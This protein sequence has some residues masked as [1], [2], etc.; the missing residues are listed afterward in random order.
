MF[1]C[2]LTGVFV[3]STKGLAA[4]EITAIDFN[5][6]LI[7]KVIPD[8]KV[9]NFDNQLI[10][11]INADS[12]IVGFKGELLG[13]II[14][15]G[16]AIG[17]D[18]KFL[19]KVSND[20]TVRLASGKII[21]KVLPNGLVVDE[22][23]DVIGAV[24]FPGLI[25]SNY[26]ET[27]GRLTGDGS[28]T[29][30]QGQ[31]IGFVSS[32]GY[33]YRQVG[34]EYVLDGKLISSKMVISDQGK[35]IGSLAPG[36]DVTDFEANI[37]GRIRANGYVYDAN[38][39]V[40]GRVV[41][42]GF[43]VGNDGKYLGFI[44]YNGEVILN[45]KVVGRLLA[46]DDIVNVEGSV[47]GKRI[48]FSATFSNEKG[49]YIGRLI[50]NGEIVKAKEVVGKLGVG[51][52]V[53]NEERI[54][55]HEVKTGPVFDYKGS[56]IGHALRN[57]AVISVL[58]TPLG[59]MKADMAYDKSGRF[60]GKISQTKL[61]MGLDN[62]IQGLT[63]IDMTIGREEEKKSVSPFGY[64]F[65][66]EGVLEGFAVKPAPI[67]NLY[68]IKAADLSLNGQIENQGNA[69][70]GKITTSGIHIDE[71]NR[72]LGAFINPKLVVDKAEES[73]YLSASNLVYNLKQ[74][75]VG[76]ITP[77]NNI[78][79]ASAEGSTNLMPKIGQAYPHS[80]VLNV[81]GNLVGYGSGERVKNSADSN[82]G[83]LI[84]RGIA[85]DNKGAFLGELASYETVVDNA[86]AFIGIVTPRGEV[87][88]YRDTYIGRPLLNGEVIS[89]SG[90]VLGHVVKALP[91]IGNAGNVLG[92]T[93]VD[94]KVI[95]Y[96]NDNLGCVDVYGRLMNVDGSIV[97]RT[98]INAPAIDFEGVIIGQ[99]NITG[100][101]ISDESKTLGYMQVDESVNSG[102]G[103][104][105]GTLFKYKYAFDN[106][107]KFIGIVN[108]EARVIGFD[109]KEIGYVD[110]YG[111]V[112]S[113]REKIG[114]ALYDLY[115]HG[116]ED[117][118]QGYIAADGNVLAFSGANIGKLDK[119][120]V[121]DKSGKVIARGSRDYNIR[122]DKYYVLGYLNFN[123]DVIANSGELAGKIE[124]KEGNIYNAEEQ[125]IAKAYPLQYYNN[126]AT[127][128]PVYGENGEII[129]YA[130]DDGS[131]VDEDGKLIALLNDDGF[132]ISANGDIIGGTGTDWFTKSTQRKVKKY[133]VPE[134]GVSGEMTEQ[135]RKSMSI[136]L[137]TDGEYLGRIG[138][139]GQVTDDSGKVLGRK[140][141]DGLIIDD[142][143]NLIGLEETAQPDTNGIFIPT[144]TF[145]QGS[146][147]GVGAGAGGNLGP[148]GGYGP[149][150][151]YDPQRSAALNEA[152]NQRRQNISVGKISTSVKTSN[153]DGMQKN[154]DEQGIQKAISS[155]RVDLSEMILSDKP[156]PAVIARSIDSNNPTPVTAY[157]ERNVYSEV[158]RNI[159]IPAGSR[160]MGTLG[161]LTATTE[162]TSQSAKVSIT[163]E[164]LIRPD[165]SIFVF[166]GLTGDAQGRGGAL[167]YLDQQLFKKYTLPVMTTMLSSGLTYMM[168]TDDSGSN[169]ESSRQQAANDA[170]QNFENSMNSIFQ[171]ILQDKTNI[172]PL[173][174]VPAGTRIIIYP[175]VDLWLRTP[176]RDE[177]EANAQLNK[178]DVLIDDQQKVRE[179]REVELRKKIN[180]SGN[181][182]GGGADSS[183]VV[184]APDQDGVS[185]ATGDALLISDRKIV[186]DRKKM[187]ASKKA[188][189]QN[190]SVGTPPPPPPS[191]ASSASSSSKE[192]TTTTTNSI[193][194]LF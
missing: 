117:S 2:V 14:P 91:V 166:Q 180:P 126:V 190:T 149:G 176:E 160:V 52:A 98:V 133:D 179:S 165:G 171:Q 78:I 187:D 156:I 58:G 168:A 167:G 116:E 70:T 48:D 69:Y 130:K 47:V 158:G 103:I 125:Y 61:V 112:N 3:L 68:G 22:I 24:L 140:M 41:S 151:R 191:S 183:S 161:G 120:F 178:K 96:N 26:G 177:L 85:I 6:D 54:L 114:Y 128:K 188:A 192:T 36:G 10:G 29:N 135:A 53:F 88:N 19:G 194:Q 90:A 86:C 101:V 31:K 147:Y 64:V 159:I 50:P 169:V 146:A 25:Y 72:V 185:E 105:L 136:A 92:I 35:F 94:G 148:G 8:G 153:F 139:D 80:I 62:T 89:D 113:G 152:Q 12:L 162:D 182:G 172:R 119:G 79:E 141:P 74:K 122:N 123:G 42:T 77:N 150:E 9:V 163:W 60:I 44:T 173:T 100:A 11:N 56:L 144:G 16:I 20:G 102:T 121:L 95:N 32:D 118:L 65:S 164:R 106:G 174:Y 132:A 51:N 40:I 43:A 83:K 15:Q 73:L 137:T 5:G 57:S 81:T 59:N 55:G 107:N 138:D 99:T 87:K 145:G 37:I 127:A 193:P 124:L 143:G 67:Y 142:G 45:E 7:G 134:V 4:Q 39:R 71:R 175:N 110:F 109:K 115:V 76:K 184:Y 181:T 34:N 17:N 75:I 155:W 93:S 1:L 84:E 111:Y 154:W 63:N 13:G 30:L 33:A 129:G 82:I 23:Y 66:A 170:R 38:N 157:V 46:N 108:E 186:E 104:P 97:G 18:N 21:G 28:Y 189:K 27:V 131:V 49:K